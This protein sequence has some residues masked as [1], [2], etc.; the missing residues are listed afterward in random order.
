MTKHEQR[1]YEY[2][3]SLKGTSISLPGPLLLAAFFA[4]MVWLF[5]SHYF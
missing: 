1:L 2:D 4:A 3:G 5:L